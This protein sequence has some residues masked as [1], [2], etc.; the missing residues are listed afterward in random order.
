MCL[1]G[2]LS[3]SVAS[4][5]DK[6]VKPGVN[7][8]FRDPDVKQFEGRFEVES[9]EVYAHRKEIV[10]ACQIQA[11]QTVAD[12][13]AGT[14]LFTRMFSDGVGQDGRVLAVD[15]SHKC[16]SNIR[17]CAAGLCS[18]KSLLPRDHISRTS[19]RRDQFPLAGPR[20]A[21]KD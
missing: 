13:G 10:A 1:V 5:Q 16:W 21:S 11:G 20:L 4:A 14:G 8:S 18:C 9:R 6:S 2:C 7:D 17:S 15:I 19:G 3:L 12:I